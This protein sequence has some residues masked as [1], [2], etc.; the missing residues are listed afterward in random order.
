MADVS[1]H[2][3]DLSTHPDVSEMR[4]RYARMLDGPQGVAVDGLVFLT[5]LYLAISAWVVH[6]NATSPEL[7]ACNLIVGL[8]VAAL[9]IGLTVAPARMLGLT[10]ATAPAGLWLIVSPWIATAGHHASA[11]MIWNNVIVGAL[12]CA[13]ALIATRMVRG[14]GE[15]GSGGG[16]AARRG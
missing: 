8:G 10:W 1:H 3:S 14:A 7:T 5:G 2:T 11:G 9:G 13:L 16:R 6:F 4:A 15:P 12:T